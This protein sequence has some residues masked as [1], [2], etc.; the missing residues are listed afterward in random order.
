MNQRRPRTVEASA[1]LALAPLAGDAGDVAVDD[2]SVTVLECELQQMLDPAL[3]GARAA[4]R[5]LPGE[6]LRRAVQVVVLAPAPGVE[7]LGVV[8][9]HRNRCDRHLYHSSWGLCT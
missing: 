4:C 6:V 3:L 2:L 1:L 8:A 9:V 7:H 5:E